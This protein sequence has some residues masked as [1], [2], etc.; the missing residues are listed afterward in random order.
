MT[1]HYAVLGAN[2][3]I[4]SALCRHLASLPD[5]RCVAVVRNRVAA[6]AVRAIAGVDVEL[7]VGS[8]ADPERARALVGDCAAVVNCAYASGGGVRANRRANLSLFDGVRRAAPDALFVHLS[9]VAVYC[10]GRIDPGRP[11]PGSSYGREKLRHERYLRSHLPADRLLVVRLGHVYGADTPI[12]RFIL[13]CLR[14]PRFRLPVGEAAA[15]NAVALERVVASLAAACL[16]GG[17]CGLHHLVDQ[18]NTTWRS[19]FDTH[20]VAFGLPGARPGEGI[21]PP[22]GGAGLIPALLAALRDTMRPPDPR[23]LA[24]SLAV[25]MAVDTVLGLAPAAT[26]RLLR[27]WYRRRTVR[28]QLA[29][30]APSMAGGMPDWLYFGPVSGPVLTDP[31]NRQSDLEALRE[32][33]CRVLDPRW[34]F[35]VSL[36]SDDATGSPVGCDRVPDRLAGQHAPSLPPVQD[37]RE[38]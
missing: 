18:P 37:E 30:G 34:A 22:P 26:E 32:W 38:G 17:P 35:D 10:P 36:H 31:G 20:A 11:R 5:I 2:G 28:A 15:S 25:R 21:A 27:R 23:M 33:G 12:S 19:L 4:G 16:Q 1:V 13:D 7:R 6:A 14:D 8:V 9:T 24:G 29:G 3:Q